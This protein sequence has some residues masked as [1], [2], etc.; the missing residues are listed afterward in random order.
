MCKRRNGRCGSWAK[1]I[2]TKNMLTEKFA[3]ILIAIGLLVLP[4]S[5]LLFLL[6]QQYSLNSPIDTE[7]FSH[8]GDFN[9]GISGSLWTLASV[10]LFYI[11]LR[12]T[13]ETYTLQKKEFE[14]SRVTLNKQQFE[15]TFFNLLVRNEHIIS[16][17]EYKKND[18][19]LWK[20]KDLIKTF[21]VEMID[22][23]NFNYTDNDALEIDKLDITDLI[24][25]YQTTYED[26]HGDIGHY[27]RNLYHIAKFIDESNLPTAEKNIYYR[28]FRAQLSNYELILLAM[29]GLTTI[30]SEFKNLIEKCGLLHN[31][32]E[33]H[34]ILKAVKSK[35]RPEAFMSYSEIMGKKDFA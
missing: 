3:K 18:N 34:N 1:S 19:A 7:I 2:E 22:N 25:Y 12:Y 20:G 26:L 30:G 15:T 27:F 28:I 11:A 16:T 35:Y 24:N 13:K 21:A 10:I 23:S 17:L 5:I 32:Y 33:Y 31:M 9:S 14:Q 29:N 6:H 4:V 8:F